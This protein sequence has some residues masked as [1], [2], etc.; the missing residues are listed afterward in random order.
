MVTNTLCYEDDHNLFTSDWVFC[1]TII[2]THAGI[3]PS[4]YNYLKLYVGN[5]CW[6]P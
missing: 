4:K 3:D 1:D 6:P 2:V 5:C